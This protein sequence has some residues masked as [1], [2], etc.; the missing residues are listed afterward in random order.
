MNENEFKKMD[1]EMMSR[2]SAL[3]E[4]KIA[5][6]LLKGFSASVERRIALRHEAPRSAKVPFLAWAPVCVVMVLASV[7]VLRS[8]VMP[9]SLSH[10]H[11][12][13]IEL[14]R[15]IVDED[16]Q[17]DL[18]ILNELGLLDD[19][20]AADLLGEDAVWNGDAEMTSAGAQSA[21]A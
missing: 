19:D 2:T 13:S 7:V 6:G 1:D 21:T 16:V 4:R 5:D 8:P 14:A 15:A 10:D 3:R 20:L 18:V 17:E 12:A 11:G 9:L